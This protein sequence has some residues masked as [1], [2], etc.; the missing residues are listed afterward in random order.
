MAHFC[1]TL[2]SSEPLCCRIPH[3]CHGNCPKQSWPLWEIPINELDRREDPTFD[4]ELTGCPLVSSCTNIQDTQQFKTLLENNFNRHY[5]T[6]RAPLSLSFNPFW[7]YSNK[8]FIEVFENWMDSVLARN[9]N[10][11]FVTNYQALLWI[12]NPTDVN[13]IPAFEEWKDKCKVEPRPSVCLN[14][15]MKSCLSG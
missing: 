5:S 3:T 10:V 11:F 8:G 15:I 14:T 2:T 12:T 1:E 4:E 9:K 13:N 7:L 6:N